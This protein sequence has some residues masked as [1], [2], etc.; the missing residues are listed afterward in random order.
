MVPLYRMTGEKCNFCTY[1]VSGAP[2]GPLY[3]L[4]G[5]KCNFC[6]HFNSGASNGPLYRLTGKKCDFCTYM[7]D[8]GEV[9]FLHIHCQ[10]WSKWSPYIGWL[11]KSAISAPTLLLVLSD[12]WD[13]HILAPLYNWANKWS[14]VKSVQ[15]NCWNS[16][17]LAPLC[18]WATP[19]GPHSGCPVKSAVFALFCHSATKWSTIQADWWKVQ[20][21]VLI[22]QWASKWPPYKAD[23]LTVL[24]QWPWNGQFKF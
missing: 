16:H 15:A 8:W 21:F 7:S 14:S 6:T 23:C 1:I 11:G 2:N 4:T 17:I 24:F 22:S 3:M 12:C 20:F 13:C 19:N 10:W 18:H 9:Q 5:K